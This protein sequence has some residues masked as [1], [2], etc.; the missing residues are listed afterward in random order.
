MLLPHLHVLQSSGTIPGQRFTRAELTL[1]ILSI[2][3]VAA[4]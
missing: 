4:S 3:G 1:I 2:M